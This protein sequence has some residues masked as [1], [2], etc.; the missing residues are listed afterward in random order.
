[1]LLCHQ[2]WGIIDQRLLNYI[3]SSFQL[4]L[5][6]H[7]NRG[8]AMAPRFFC[9]GLWQG[10]ARSLYC[11]WAECTHF[12]RPE[13]K[14]SLRAVEFR[15]WWWTSPPQF[16][17]RKLR[18]ADVI[19]H[20]LFSWWRSVG[21]I[22]FWMPSGSFRSGWHSET[23]PFSSFAH[24]FKEI[25]YLFQE[26]HQPDIALVC[27]LNDWTP[28]PVCPLDEKSSCRWTSVR[29]VK[30]HLDMMSGHWK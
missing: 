3:W 2:K 15:A 10:S 14:C 11:A 30:R 28:C 18:G 6:T 22:I 8:A 19:F 4:D 21:N 12:F 26:Q 1:L 5:N 13:N 16:S 7:V 9:L 17:S 24:K 20:A 27:P 25:A 23:I 29:T